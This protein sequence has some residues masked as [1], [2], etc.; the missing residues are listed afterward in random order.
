MALGTVAGAISYPFKADEVMG[1]GLAVMA[2]AAVDSVKLA[3]GQN[4]A[5]IGITNFA[6]DAIG[7]PA[8]V[9][10]HGPVKAVA[11]GVITRGDYVM[12]DAATGK[13]GSIGAVGGTNYN[14]VGRAMEAAAAQNDEI[15][16]F[17]NPTIIQAA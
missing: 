1:A 8:S 2:G 10:L 7:R 11:N 9:V 6:V 15:L 14:V 3:T 5:A 12:A 17:V 16:V 13:V 4:A